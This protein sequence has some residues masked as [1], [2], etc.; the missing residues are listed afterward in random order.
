MDR[1]KRAS[2]GLWPAGSKN[3][4]ERELGRRIY[5]ETRSVNPDAA[6]WL[7]ACIREDRGTIQYASKASKAW[8]STSST[9]CPAAGKAVMIALMI[10]FRSAPAFLAA[11]EW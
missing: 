10:S 4:T 3:L 11:R 2:Q 8:G 7:S 9:P 6:P 5:A 1:G